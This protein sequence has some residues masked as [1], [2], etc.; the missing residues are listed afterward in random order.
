MDSHMPAPGPLH[1]RLGA[2][3][4]HWAGPEHMQPSP[5]SPEPQT[6][7]GAIRGRMLDGFFVITEYEQTD[8][9]GAV[10]FRGHGVYSV[11]PETDECLM[12]WF[13]SMGGKGGTAR[14]GFD[15]NRLVFEN[16]SPMGKHRYA[17]TFEDGLTVFEMAMAPEGGEWTTLMRGEYAA[18]D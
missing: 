14:G 10:T 18:V 12:Y 17:Y 16:S 13:D 4:G 5:W 7:R 11:D 6:R 9:S 8:D 3:T 15:G 1:Q 2:L